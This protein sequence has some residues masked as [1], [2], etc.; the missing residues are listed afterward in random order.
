MGV[1]MVSAEK[2]SIKIRIFAWKFPALNNIVISITS[3]QKLQ[4]TGWKIYVMDDTFALNFFR[5]LL[6][7]GVHLAT[8]GKSTNWY[9]NY[10]SNVYVLE[11]IH[12]KLFIVFIKFIAFFP[13]LL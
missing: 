12:F 1:A 8:L 3:Y 6:A 7:Y 9:L 13:I 11:Q 10:F 5:I 4:F 2:A